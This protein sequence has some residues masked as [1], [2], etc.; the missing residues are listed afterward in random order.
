MK[1]AQQ[2]YF[3]KLLEVINSREP[4]LASLAISYK[5]SQTLELKSKIID[6]I[7][8]A[9]EE[10]IALAIKALRDCFGLEIE[11][12]I[13]ID[14][15]TYTKDGKSLADRIQSR[16]NQVE[17]L[18]QIGLIYWLTLIQSNECWTVYNEL[19]YNQ[20]KTHDIMCEITHTDECCIECEEEYD[21]ATI[22]IQQLRERPP[23]HPG[24]QCQVI[25]YNKRNEE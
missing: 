13:I 1:Q 21:G 4:K 25:Y 2:K 16:L 24:C 23:F 3:N 15:L 12:K 18:N 17:E 5:K 7:Y 22:P 10:T 8:S 11:T 14:S 9:L 20:L 19:L 6:C